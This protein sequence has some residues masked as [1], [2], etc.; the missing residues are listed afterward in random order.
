MRLCRG[1]LL[2]TAF[3][4]PCSSQRR[5]FGLLRE[6]RKNRLNHFDKMERMKYQFFPRE[7][8]RTQNYSLGAPR[9]I[10]AARR[11]DRLFF[12]RSS[13]G[14]DERLSL[15]FADV[16]AS[17]DTPL[18]EILLV[19]T[20]DLANA[21]R[22][23]RRD[24]LAERLRKE[25]V[26]ESADGITSYTIDDLGQLTA[27]ALSGDIFVVDVGTKSIVKSIVDLQASDLTLSPSG[28][29]LAFVSGG[30][31]FVTELG[32][33]SS[34]IAVSPPS[35]ETHTWGL[36]D[37][38]AAE[39]MHR[40]EGHWWSPDG[41]LLLYCGVE[42]SDL[43]TW[44]ISNPARPEKEPARVRYPVAGSSNARL[45]IRMW[46]HISKKTTEVEWDTDRFPYL[47]TVEWIGDAPILVLQDRSQRL[48]QAIRVDRTNGTTTPIYS[49]TDKT[50]V[51]LVPGVPKWLD[52]GTVI[53]APDEERRR[54]YV[55]GVPVSSEQLEVRGVAGITE[56]GDVV[57]VGSTDPRQTQV[58]MWRHDSGTNTRLSRDGGVWSAV[59]GG[60]TVVLMGRSLDFTGVQVLPI[61][62]DQGNLQPLSRLPDKSRRMTI[63]PKPRFLTTSKHRVDVAVLL[64]ENSD[65][66]ARL[67]VLL[68]PYGG[69]WFR[70]VVDSPTSFS[71]SQWFAEQGFLVVVA[72]GRGTPG[73]GRAWEKAV[74]GDLA[75]VVLSDQ[76]EALDEVAASYP[77]A[78][79]SKVAIRGWSFGGYLAALAAIRCPERIHAAVAGAPV[80][81]WRLYDTHYS[82]RYLGLPSENEEAYSACSVLEDAARLRRPLLVIHGL[83]DD[84]VVA[85][86]SLNLSHVLFRAGIEHAVLPLKEITHMTAS[87][88]ASESILRIELSFLKRSLALS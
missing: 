13:S 70:R 64:P 16:P 25:R 40:L 34:P 60:R 57:Y 85:A 47:V 79:L 30:Q 6:Y 27:F 76:L 29:H 66:V 69:P 14:D 88:N 77:Q 58:W 19:D 3:G 67:P 15:W 61:R 50:W 62:V 39:E 32:E 65:S 83:A 1:I 53:D 22:S 55:G 31:L 11:T 87:E 36:P 86:H 80:T 44:Y 37:F 35:T 48:V 82:E 81:D 41:D 45:S 59:V 38:I 18:T 63:P 23:E 8:A 42:S 9:T 24:P 68:D 21:A 26:R 72:D 74:A 12:L 28:S 49:K 75:S 52:S 46:S 5:R 17:S 84:N 43:P 54:L 71:V 4:T 20:A 2:E 56:F 78:D 7:Y 10:R 73:K 51:E 33:S